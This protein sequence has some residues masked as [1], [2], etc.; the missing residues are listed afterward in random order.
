MYSLLISALNAPEVA[1]VHYMFKK[2]Y[3]WFKLY[4]LTR[5]HVPS[6]GRGP[7]PKPGYHVTSTP[8]AKYLR[9]GDALSWNVNKSCSITAIIHLNYIFNKRRAAAQ[10]AR[11]RCKFLY[12]LFREYRH[13]RASRL[14]ESELVDSSINLLSFVQHDMNRWT[15]LPYRHCNWVRRNTTSVTSDRRKV[16]IAPTNNLHWCIGPN[17]K[18][19]PNPSVTEP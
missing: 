10:T 18:P 12:A 8:Y 13:T 14:F 16:R 15:H 17:R 1:Y 5:S 9:I 19:K 7:L 2:I 11:S 6:P 3:Y 4:F